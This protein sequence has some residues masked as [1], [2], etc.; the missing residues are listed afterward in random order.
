MEVKIDLRKAYNFLNWIYIRAC[1]S[2]FGF[3]NSWIDL[4]MN[5]ITTVSF[6]IL[7]NGKPNGHFQPKWGLK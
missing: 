5:Y 6:S 2:C 7:I 4:V 3:S 1:F